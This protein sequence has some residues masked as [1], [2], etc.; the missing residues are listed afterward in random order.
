MK[1]T[2]TRVSQHLSL[3]LSQRASSS[4][5]N[6]EDANSTWHAP[7]PLLTAEFAESVKNKPEKPH[8]HHRSDLNFNA[9]SLRLLFNRLI[10]H[11]HNLALL[12]A[13]QLCVKISQN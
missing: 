7:I 6:Q 8:T 11:I 4:I 1:S 2:L 12:S 10:I 13:L 9:K 3:F 5:Q